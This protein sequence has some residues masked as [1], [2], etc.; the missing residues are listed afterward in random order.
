MSQRRSHTISAQI[1][2]LALAK[3]QWQRLLLLPK[4]MHAG[5]TDGADRRRHR[6]KERVSERKRGN[7]REYGNWCSQQMFA[8]V[9]LLQLHSFWHFI[10][11]TTEGA[12]EPYI[13]LKLI[14][15]PNNAVCLHRESSNSSNLYNQLKL[16]LLMTQTKSCCVL[17]SVETISWLIN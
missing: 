5:Y 2:Q 11:H 3:R 8:T 16:T 10:K 1:S 9:P 6:E 13:F 7:E 12:V 14:S 17:T 4:P 15:K